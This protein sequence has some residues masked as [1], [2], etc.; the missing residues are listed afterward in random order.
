MRYLRCTLRHIFF[1][2]RR[3]VFI[4][5]KMHLWTID[6]ITM[7]GFD[8]IP[9]LANTT[10][11]VFQF[12]KLHVVQHQMAQSGSGMWLG[13]NELCFTLNSQWNVPTWSIKILT[14]YSVPPRTPGW[15]GVFRSHDTGIGI[16]IKH[17]WRSQLESLWRR[18]GAELSENLAYI[19][20]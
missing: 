6:A 20:W 15:L 10:I 8:L 17:T 9:Y 3:H 14:M 16:Q 13:P 5:S 12:W 4:T 7:D 19:L 1:M 2:K 11:V 18:V